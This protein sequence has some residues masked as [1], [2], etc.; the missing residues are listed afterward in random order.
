MV[1]SWL[2]LGTN[3]GSRE[4]NLALA[5]AALREVGTIEAVSSVYESEPVGYR[6]QPDFWNV[7]VRVRTALPP[8]AL[9]AAMQEIEHRLGRRRSFPNAP[10][11]IDIDL[12]LYG[13]E[14]HESERL[15][16]PHPRLTERAFV[17]RPLLE[18][19]PELRHPVTGERLHDY[20]AAGG[21][22]RTELLFPGE[23][24]LRS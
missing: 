3:M 20:L 22:E 7:V 18:L 17:L 11:P 13:S 10:R 2:G 1:T 14:V 4:E 5:L 15:I 16:I 23:K 8:E 9:L 19:D 6:E 21:L 24:L 12:L